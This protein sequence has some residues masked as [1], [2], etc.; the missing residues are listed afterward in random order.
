[1]KKKPLDRGESSELSL[2]LT[3][4]AFNSSSMREL[5]EIMSHKVLQNNTCNNAIPKAEPA[6]EDKKEDKNKSDLMKTWNKV[7]ISV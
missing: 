1:M 6:I 3:T 2:S 5:Q 7:G 4:K